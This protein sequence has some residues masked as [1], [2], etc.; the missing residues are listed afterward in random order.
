[1]NSTLLSELKGLLDPQKL[2]TLLTAIQEIAAGKRLDPVVLGE[3]QATILELEEQV[4]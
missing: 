2:L 3:I 1:M 4:K